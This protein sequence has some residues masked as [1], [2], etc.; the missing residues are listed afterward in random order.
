MGIKFVFIAS[1][2][3]AASQRGIF[4]VEGFGVGIGQILTQGALVCNLL[5]FARLV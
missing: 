3:N 5:I 4:L 2:M 1:H